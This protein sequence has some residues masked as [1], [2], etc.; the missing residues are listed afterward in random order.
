[1]AWAKA[2]YGITRFRADIS[3]QNGPSLRLIRKLGFA[4]I[5]TQQHDRR[6]EELVFHHDMTTSG[7]GQQK[8]TNAAD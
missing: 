8:D 3:P 5:G 4:Q 7:R 6:G 2:E 1:M